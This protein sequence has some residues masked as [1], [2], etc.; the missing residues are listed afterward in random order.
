PALRSV[1]ADEA[2]TLV[3]TVGGWQRRWLAELGSRFVFLADEIYLLAGLALPPAAP[4]EGFPI[5]A[6]RIRLLRPFGGGSARA[7]ARRRAPSRG[8]GPVTVVT[9]AM[10][11]P[12]LRALLAQGGFDPAETR[13]AAV[14]NDFFGQAIG[15]AGLLT[16]RDIQRQLATSP[17]LGRA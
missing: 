2:R 12:R 14:S 10:F 17:D 16:G 6:D 4:Y 9:G 1:S 8:V 15:V 3:V 5:A 7:I 11:A 13:V